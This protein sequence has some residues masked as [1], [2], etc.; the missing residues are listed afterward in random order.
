MYGG[1]TTNFLSYTGQSIFHVQSGK[2]YATTTQG[3]TS[4]YGALGRQ[5]YGKVYISLGVNDFS[6]SA[7]SYGAAYRDVVDRVKQLQ[8]NA[9]IYL[10]TLAPIN[11]PMAHNRGYTVTNATINAFNDQIKAIAAEKQTFCIDVHAYFVNAEGSLNADECWDGIHLDITA[12]QK[13][14]AFL[15]TQIF[16]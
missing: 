15:K 14:A 7:A 5:T 8:P 9:A 4:I 10:L 11:E 2:T 1:L 16:T 3:K 12:N 13:M 6:A